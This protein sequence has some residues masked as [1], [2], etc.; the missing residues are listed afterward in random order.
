M[1]IASMMRGCGNVF[2]MRMIKKN[3]RKNKKISL[4]S[5]YTGQGLQ[6]S[7]NV[8]MGQNTAL[9]HKLLFDMYVLDI[10]H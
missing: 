3:I 7:I 10:D 1:W 6:A 9:Y 2:E 4:S 5:T 8:C